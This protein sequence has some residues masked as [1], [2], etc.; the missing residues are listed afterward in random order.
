M[1]QEQILICWAAS[2]KLCPQ[3]DL[4]GELQIHSPGLPN[5]DIQNLLMTALSQTSIKKNEAGQWYIDSWAAAHITRNVGKFLNLI[6]Y[7]G[8]DTVITEYGTHHSISHTRN[9]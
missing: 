5:T 9:V 1:G 2:P 6:P 7:K 8:H 3:I 4:M